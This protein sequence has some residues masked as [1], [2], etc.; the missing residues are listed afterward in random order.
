MHW[1]EEALKQIE[2][3]PAFIRGMAKRAVEKEVAKSGREEVT[4]ED[5]RAAYE[6]YIKFAVNSGEGKGQEKTTKIAIVRCDVVAEVCPGIACFKAF[7]HRKLAFEQY[8]DHAEIIGFFT[9]G[10]CPGRRVPRLVEKLIPHGLDVVH[11]S[12]CMMLDD[13]YPR[14]PHKNQIKKII[15]KKG[16]R[17]IEGT[18]H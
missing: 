11:L 15:E 2:K 5:V 4:A 3:A 6:K 14:C 13:D 10:G 16:I 17:V 7:N 18:H 1:S 9:C 8:G 12:S